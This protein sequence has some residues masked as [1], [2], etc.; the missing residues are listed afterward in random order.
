[1][2]KFDTSELRALS[3]AAVSDQLSPQDRVRLSELC[4]AYMDLVDGFNY[5]AE[6]TLATQEGLLAVKRTPKHEIKRYESI[7]AKIATTASHHVV[8]DR[9]I[10]QAP[11]TRLKQL[12][13][14]NSA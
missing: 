1:M 3:N 7:V 8:T 13:E 12:V 11:T 10:S 5:L 4:H 9:T 6:C 2:K 14:R